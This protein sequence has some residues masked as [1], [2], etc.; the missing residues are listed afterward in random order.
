MALVG[1]I[2]IR[3]FLSN[4]MDVLSV[5]HRDAVSYYLLIT[6]WSSSLRNSVISKAGGEVHGKLED[7]V[8]VSA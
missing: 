8:W 4:A 2:R 5:G 6:R 1:C 7:N 3:A